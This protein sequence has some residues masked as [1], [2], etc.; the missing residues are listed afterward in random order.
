MAART[1]FR[2]EKS[3]A[4]LPRADAKHGALR[5]WR[6]KMAQ[7]NQN[8]REVL[9]GQLR[10]ARSWADPASSDMAAV[11]PHGLDQCDRVA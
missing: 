8:I 7:V 4:I 1:T 9:R 2:H 3:L 11:I 5:R 6:R 10:P